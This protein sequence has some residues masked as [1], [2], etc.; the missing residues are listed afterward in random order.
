MLRLGIAIIKMS[1]Y[2]HF[3]WEVIMAMICCVPDH[4]AASLAGNYYVIIF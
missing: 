3:G 1:W 2:L 4:V